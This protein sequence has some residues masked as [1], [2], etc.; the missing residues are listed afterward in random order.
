[1]AR[2]THHSLRNICW[3][4]EQGS[5]RSLSKRSNN[6]GLLWELCLQ[7]KINAPVV[8]ATISSEGGKYSKVMLVRELGWH[9]YGVLCPGRPGWLDSRM[10]EKLIEIK[11]ERTCHR[12]SEWH[13][14][15]QGS[16]NSQNSQG[17]QSVCRRRRRRCSTR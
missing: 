12:I 9:V 2:E 6:V 10:L 16:A 17:V 8:G 13:T 7:R 4:D 11:A 5:D 14:E 15:P 3:K 1:M